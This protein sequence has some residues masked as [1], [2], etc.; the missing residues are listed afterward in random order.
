MNLFIYMGGIMKKFYAIALLTLSFLGLNTQLNTADA[1]MIFISQFSDGK[2]YADT[3]S[4]TFVKD[5]NFATVW[6][7][8]VIG[9]LNNGKQKITTY[10][11]QY[12]KYKQR[13]YWTYGSQYNT[14]KAIDFNNT[15]HSN[16]TILSAY[17][18]SHDVLF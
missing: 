13:Y 10:Y 15:S 9:N 14:P 1:Q 16:S 17:W 4:A 5:D 8:N 6:A 3:S 18:A 2:Y 11:F 12:N 7:I